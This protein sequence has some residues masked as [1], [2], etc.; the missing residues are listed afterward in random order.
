VTTPIPVLLYHSVS[1]DPPPGSAWGAVS[2]A[3]FA[4]HAEAIG[5]SNRQPITVTE[6]AAGL[7][8]ETPLPARPIAVT[9]DDGYEDTETAVAYLHR[10][11][12][13]STVYVTTGT[14]GAP[15]HATPDQIRAIALLEGVEIGAHSVRH[16]RLDELDEHEMVDEV[17]RSRA[18]LEALIADWVWSF[19]YPHGAHNRRVRD[20]VV[21]AGYRSAAAVKNAI[22]HHADDPFALA[23]WTVMSGTR[24]ERIADVLEGRR[25]PLASGRERWV[26]R[27]YRITRRGRRRVA[28]ARTRC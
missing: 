19:A 11:G 26:T 12:I 7:R 9:F 23:R 5:A 21:A 3:E 8:G 10:R 1:D 13:V 6:L 2:R 20:E 16:Q 4:A 27:A 24:P 28:K 17:R 22:S 25:V 15:G 14:V 18:Q